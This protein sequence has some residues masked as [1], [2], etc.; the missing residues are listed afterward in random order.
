MKCSFASR[1]FMAT[2]L[3]L[4]M[5]EATLADVFPV[6][7]ATLYQGKPDL[8]RV[9]FVP[10]EVVYGHKTYQPGADQNELPNRADIERLALKLAKRE[11]LVVLDFEKWPVQGYWDE[12]DRMEANRKRYLTLLRWFKSAAPNV[13]FGY[14]G[15]LPVTNFEGSI[16]NAAE[17]KH[18]AWLDENAR[19]FALAAE[20]D[21]VF[22]DAY[23]YRNDR[24]QWKQSLQLHLRELRK[25]YT[26]EVYVFL[27]PQFFDHAPTPED[28]RLKPIPEDFWRFQLQSAQEMVEG[29]V[30]WGGWNFEE[31]QPLPWDTAA[32][33]WIVTQ[34]F[35]ALDVKPGSPKNLRMVDK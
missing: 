22:L 12:P 30:V 4:S 1:F 6:R 13:R 23:T 32:P 17:R 21:V 24:V 2:A 31:N 20:T 33:W 35:L 9:G 16:A 11:K 26:G 3:V 19:M 14:F 34:E 29:V 25:I 15:V 8:S 5:S 7:D 28:L 10:I 27:W 18:K